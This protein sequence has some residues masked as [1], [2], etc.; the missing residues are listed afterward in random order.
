MSFTILA[1]VIAC[2][3]LFGLIAFAAEQRKKEMG[4]R[5]VLGSSVMGIVKLL[6]KDLLKL[7]VIAIAIATPIAWFAMNK[8]LQDFAYR[9]HI[10]WW[11]FAG[12]GILALLIAIVTVSVQAIKAATANQI[13]ALRSE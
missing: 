12:A 13:N 11:V 4:I 9:I 6:C 8:W 7:V 2:L 5:K 3:G 10:A 1:I